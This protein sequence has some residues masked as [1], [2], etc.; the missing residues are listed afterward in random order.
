MWGDQVGIIDALDAMDFVGPGKSGLERLAEK[1][2]PFI[3]SFYGGRRKF[4]EPLDPY[5]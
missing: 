1:R 4:V 5:S 2:Q 3:Y